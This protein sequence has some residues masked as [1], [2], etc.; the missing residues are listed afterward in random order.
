MSGERER[1]FAVEICNIMY[2]IIIIMVYETF[3]STTSEAT[4]LLAEHA[5]HS[6]NAYTTMHI[7]LTVFASLFTRQADDENDCIYS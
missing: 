7:I 5:H 3:C 1:A 4:N 2:I 6:R